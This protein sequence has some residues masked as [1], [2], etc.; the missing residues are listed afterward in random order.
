LLIGSAEQGSAS[1]SAAEKRDAKNEIGWR[2]QPGGKR[3]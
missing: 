3:R 2:A 1:E